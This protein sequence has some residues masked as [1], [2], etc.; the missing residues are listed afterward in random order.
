[1]TGSLYARCGR[2]TTRAEYAD[3]V[4]KVLVIGVGAGSPGH[5]TLDAVAAMRRASVF[6][7]L[8]KGDRKADLLDFR[9]DILATHLGDGGFRLVD[10]PDPPRD[11]DPADYGAVV[12]D[13]HEARARL[14]A[15]TIVDEVGEDGVAGI[16]V[17][18]DPSLYD[19]TLR[20]L[21]RVR[22]HGVALDVEVIPGVTAVSALAAAHAIC[23]NRIGEPIHI[24]TGRRLISTTPEDRRNVVVMLDAHCTFREVA[25]ADTFIWWGAYLGSPGQILVAGP[26]S[27]VGEEI[28]RRRAEARE[29]HGWIMDTYL[30][31]QIGPGARTGGV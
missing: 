15:E 26:V 30:L 24:T 10:I 29:R 1:M 22:G 4:R 16:L 27:E 14:L 2:H 28:V 9:R 31:R 6:L 18:G 3:G 23:L 21:D 17:W 7:A 19:S 12:E 5:L 11:R 13:W 8:D 25:D 20:I